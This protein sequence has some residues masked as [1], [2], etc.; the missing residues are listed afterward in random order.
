[1]LCID[2]ILYILIAMVT[3]NIQPETILINNNGIPHTLPKRIST[4]NNCLYT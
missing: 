1:M 4:I 2:N 3:N